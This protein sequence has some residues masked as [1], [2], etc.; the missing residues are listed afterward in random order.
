MKELCLKQLFAETPIF[1]K[2]PRVEYLSSFTTKNA[3]GTRITET[4]LFSS[5]I[6]LSS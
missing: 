6:N 5:F 3:L 4:P 2:V 1:P